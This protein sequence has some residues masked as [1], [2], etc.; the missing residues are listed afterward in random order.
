MTELSD[1]LDSMPEPTSSVMNEGEYIE[2]ANHLKELY[3]EM[4]EKNIKSK[5]DLI[6]L[7]KTLTSAYGLSRIIDNMS[8]EVIIDMPPEMS[9]LIQVLRGML[10]EAMDIYVFNIDAMNL[11]DD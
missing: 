6:E 11:N 1:L 9:L 3:K 2:M 7:K 8:D 4:T 10:S 5:T